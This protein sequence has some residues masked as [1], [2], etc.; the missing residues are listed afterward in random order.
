MEA[1]F[2]R[3][4]TLRGLCYPPTADVFDRRRGVSRVR[5]DRLGEGGEHLY[6]VILLALYVKDHLPRRHQVSPADR[7]W[8][9]RT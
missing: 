7:E 6:R 3:S 9:E 8:S 2:Y 4:Y 1:F 5:P